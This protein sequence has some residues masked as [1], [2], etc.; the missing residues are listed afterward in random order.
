[1]LWSRLQSF[2]VSSTLLH[3]LSKFGWPRLK[4]CAS[5][6]RINAISWPRK[7][8]TVLTARAMLAKAK[9]LDALKAVII[10]AG[11]QVCFAKSRLR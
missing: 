10:E 5:S 2:A 6:I 7:F 3:R 9:N 1:M 8:G 11:R 4:L